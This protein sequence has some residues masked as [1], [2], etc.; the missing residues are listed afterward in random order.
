VT[1][2]RG[3]VSLA[4]GIALLSPGIACRGESRLV[5]PPPGPAPVALSLD[6]LRSLALDAVV[7]GR[8]VRVVSLY[9]EAPDYRPTPSPARDGAPSR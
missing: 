4:L 2:S 5:P 8:P 3:V 1:A 6:H 7:N 9:A